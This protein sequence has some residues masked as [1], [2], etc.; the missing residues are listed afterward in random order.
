[1]KNS[2][3]RQTVDI[4]MYCMCCWLNPTGRMQERV[5]LVEL[6]LHMIQTIPHIVTVAYS[7][8]IM[9][10]ILILLTH[11]LCNVM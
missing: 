3:K 2:L 6:L 4:A 7:Y 1:M 8:S 5:D 9:Y 10:S 11:T